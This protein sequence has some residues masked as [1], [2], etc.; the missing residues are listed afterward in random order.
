[1]RKKNKHYNEVE[2][3]FTMVLDE[4]ITQA[5]ELITLNKDCP[6]DLMFNGLN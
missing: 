5:F 3:T 1:M 4:K 6:Y 2:R